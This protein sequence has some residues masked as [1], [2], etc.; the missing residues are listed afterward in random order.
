MVYNILRKLINVGGKMNTKVN[1]L[2]VIIIILLMGIFYIIFGF[3]NQEGKESASISRQI[4][5]SITKNIQ[6]IQELEPSKKEEVLSR[7]EH[8][9]R[10]L[11]HFSLYTVVGILSMSLMST[12]NLKQSKR[13][14]TSLGIGIIYAISDEIHQSFIPDRSAQIGDVLIDTAGVI[15]GIIIVILIIKVYCVITKK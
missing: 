11:A 15:T 6:S 14:I 12:Y 9:I 8:Y 2:R 7:I 4:T 1:I 13:I 3:S 5:E 10:K